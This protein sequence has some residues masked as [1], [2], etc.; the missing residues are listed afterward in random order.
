M[1][2]YI[3]LLAGIFAFN[4]LRLNG[5]WNKPEFTWLQFAKDNI[6][7]MIVAIILGSAIISSKSIAD[8]FINIA[9]AGMDLSINLYIILGIG[10]DTFVKKIYE[11]VNPKKSTKVGLNG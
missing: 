9:F 5:A 2:N 1:M 6:I 7:S 3:Y 8:E 11:I 4:L 10:F